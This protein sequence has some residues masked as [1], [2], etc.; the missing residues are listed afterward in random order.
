M[1][2]VQVKSIKFG[3]NAKPK[4]TTHTTCQCRRTAARP[5]LA[6]T[7]SSGLVPSADWETTSPP[8]THCWL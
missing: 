7:H 3:V 5:P 6:Q 1:N 8:H 2:V 4:K